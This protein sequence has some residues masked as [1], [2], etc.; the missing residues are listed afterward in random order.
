MG[1]ADGAGNGQY[2]FESFGYERTADRRLFGGGN[3]ACSRRPHPD[4]VR[5]ALDEWRSHPRAMK[6]CSYCGR[7]NTDDAVYCAECGTG[8]FRLATLKGLQAATEA[9]QQASETDAVSKEDIQAFV[10]TRSYCY[11][12]KWDSLD[13]ILRHVA[14]GTFNWA[15]C[16]LTVFWMAYRRMYLYVIIWVAFLFVFYSIVE[17]LLKLP[18]SASSGA[19]I[20]M[21]FLFGR[22]GSPLYR[23]HVE[24]KIREIKSTLPPEYWPQAFR[25]KGG[26]SAWAPIPLV[27]LHL[28]ALYGAYVNILERKRQGQPARSGGSYQSHLETSSHGSGL[29]I[30]SHSCFEDRVLHNK[31]N[32][33]TRIF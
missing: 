19:T 1:V 29:H 9:P 18:A 14:P 20:A 15:A 22:Y 25:D 12:P 27:I 28:L 21:M 13:P 26:T 7:E 2:P 16:F 24:R 6:H 4:I 17:V 5:T 8:D 33:S 32:L 31:P 3:I 30:V 11:V 10:Q 23:K